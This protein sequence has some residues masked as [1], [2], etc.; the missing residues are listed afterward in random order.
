MVWAELSL[1]SNPNIAFY[2]VLLDSS[3]DG[4]RYLSDNEA[5]DLK[6]DL[7]GRYA[8]VKG[9]RNCL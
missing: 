1:T 3:S 7:E 6:Q 5:G 4:K 9:K 8:T 2:V